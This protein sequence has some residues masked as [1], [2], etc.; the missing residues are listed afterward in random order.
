MGAFAIFPS[1]Y[2]RKEI[3]VNMPQEKIR[4][5]AKNRTRRD[6]LKITGKSITGV[7]LS[8]SALN[9]LGCSPEKGTE[10]QAYAAAKGVIFTAPERCVGCLRCETNCTAFNDGKIQPSLSRVKT[11]RSFNFGLGDIESDY[12]NKDGMYGNYR[13]NPDPCRQC[14]EPACAL[15]CPMG[16]IEAAPVTGARVVNTVKCVGCG[17]C[18]LACPW[19]LP[20]VDPQT[21]KSTKCIL[22]G[23]CAANCPT[24]AL[25]LVPWKEVKTAV[26]RT[27]LNKHGYALA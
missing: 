24:G 27:V 12:R 2:Y 18:T 10:A 26:T 16:A 11:Y 21:H 1:F 23:I 9:L 13:I 19:H 6:F 22:C 8:M 7:A 14:K 3:E 20:T 15:N 25:T 4:F 17:S 5:L